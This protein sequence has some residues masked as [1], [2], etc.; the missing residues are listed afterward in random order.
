MLARATI[1]GPPVDPTEM[2]RQL[3]IQ[4]GV[5]NAVIK[6]FRQEASVGMSVPGAVEDFDAATAKGQAARYM[7]RQGTAL[8]LDAFEQNVTIL[9]IGPA[10]ARRR[11]LQDDAGVSVNVSIATD[12]DVSADLEGAN[13]SSGFSAAYVEAASTV[14][15]FRHDKLLRSIGVNQAAVMFVKQ[16]P[17]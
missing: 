2:L 8:P 9:G 1:A 10:Q 4:H 16:H 11:R 5:G 7:I 3:E 14:A 17:Y 6:S 12:T 15:A 13:F